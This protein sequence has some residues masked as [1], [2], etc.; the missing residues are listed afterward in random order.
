V[1][2]GEIVEARDRAAW[3]RWLRRNHDRGSGAWLA[4]A[5][6]GGSVPAPGY[7]DAVLEALCFG[8]IDS[9]GRRLDDDRSLIW[10]APRKPR[11][12]WSASNKARVD[13]LVRDGLMEAPGLAAIELAKSNGAWEALERIDLL[14]VPKDLAAAFRKHPGSRKHWNAFPPSV[15]KQILWW[16]NSAKRD[17]TRAKRV[18]ETA[19]LAARNER[20]NQWR[21]KD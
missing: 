3:R 14:E 7:E 1:P 4:I 11:S 17:E 2:E 5:K 16:I 15:Q 6:K 9:T 18:M 12:N 10:M 13:V 8:W 21:P 19:S 20:A